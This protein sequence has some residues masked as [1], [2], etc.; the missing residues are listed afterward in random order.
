MW[1]TV[2]STAARPEDPAVTDQTLFEIK[3]RLFDH[4][5]EVER[6]TPYDQLERSSIRGCLSDVGK[7]GFEFGG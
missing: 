5:A 3:V 6:R 7:S 4:L 1:R 2:R